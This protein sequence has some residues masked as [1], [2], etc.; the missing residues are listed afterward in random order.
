MREDQQVASSQGST[1]IEVTSRLSELY[2]FIE[3]RHASLPTDLN[4]VEGDYEDDDSD[5]PGVEELDSSHQFN[6]RMDNLCDILSSFDEGRTP[7]EYKRDLVDNEQPLISF[8]DI[9]VQGSISATICRLAIYDEA[10]HWRLSQ[11][12]PRDVCARQ[13]YIK[14]RQ[15]A[16]LA[17]RWLDHYARNGPQTGPARDNIPEQWRDMDVPKCAGALRL[18]VHQMCEDRDRRTRN[19]PLDMGVESLLA[20]T[21]TDLVQEVCFH[22]R[23]IYEGSSWNRVQEPTEQDRE[24]NLYAYLIGNPPLNPSFPPWMRDYFVIDQ[25]RAFPVSEQRHLFGCLTSIKENVHERDA[26]VMPASRAY[27]V[28]I[29]DMLRDYS[30]ATT[31]DEP[32]SS[33]AHPW[34]A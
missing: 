30:Y 5:E 14:Q 12:V 19:A 18:L 17:V 15:R 13:Y 21:L 26:D 29:E 22:N 10:F 25:L 34:R 32:S 6:T 9:L 11:I 1:Q 24:R 16:Q 28:M 20:E 23:D 4:N 7:S 8:D 3:E 31:A 2:P 33:S 27:V